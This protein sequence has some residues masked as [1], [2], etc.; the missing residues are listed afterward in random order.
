MAEYTLDSRRVEQVARIPE[1]TALSLTDCLHVTDAGLDHLAVLG[2][3]LQALDLDGC[4]SLTDAALASSLGCMLL[5][6]RFCCGTLWHPV[7]QW[8]DSY[9]SPVTLTQFNSHMQV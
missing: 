4:V 2:G 5:A 6:M 1:L 8:F 3:Q 9:R 7:A